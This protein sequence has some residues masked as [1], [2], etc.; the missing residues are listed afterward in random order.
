[1][2]TLGPLTVMAD[3][4]QGA[5]GLFA[6]LTEQRQQGIAAVGIQ[7][8]GGLVGDDQG[9]LAEQGPGGGHPLLLAERQ[10]PGR[11]G[12]GGRVQ[13]QASQQRLGGGPALLVVAGAFALTASPGKAGT[14]A[15]I[16]H[17]IQVRQQIEGLE[18]D[19]NMVRPKGVPTPLRQGG[20]RFACHPDMAV[21]GRTNTGYQRQ[22]G[23]FAAAAGAME[24]HS[25]TGLQGKVVDMNKRPGLPRVLI[26]Q[27]IQFKNHGYSRGIRVSPGA[28]RRA[29]C[30]SGNNRITS[31]VR[32]EKVARNG[33]VTSVSLSGD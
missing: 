22:Q 14:E 27:V 8:G 18:D 13:S 33:S 17:R 3:H 15:D 26:T 20:K 19:A 2:K 29:P 24:Q 21:P 32:P 23:T 5:A 30:P 9:R 28:R 7:G 1:M 11:Q 10:L 31:V 25:L 6:L 4:Q 12:R 16:I